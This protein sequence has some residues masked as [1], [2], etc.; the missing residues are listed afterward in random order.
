MAD[1]GISSTSRYYRSVPLLQH[2]F[3]YESFLQTRVWP[4][5]LQEEESGMV[6]EESRLLWLALT[7]H[8]RAQILDSL[9]PPGPASGEA[10]DSPCDALHRGGV[11]RPLNVRDEYEGR[12]I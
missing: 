9:A 4:R 10:L 7:R 6:L 12:Q 11:L 2:L 1:H 5:G 8:I 3:M